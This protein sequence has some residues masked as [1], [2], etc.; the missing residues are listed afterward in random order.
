[1]VLIEAGFLGEGELV[2]LIELIRKYAA[3]NPLLTGPSSYRSSSTVHLRRLGNP[4][5]AAVEERIA[6]YVGLNPKTAEGLQGAWY[7]PGESYRIHH[8]SFHRGTKEWEQCVGTAG[9]R[10]WS[11]MAYLNTGGGETI[12]P[13]L[14]VAIEPRAGTLV[15]WANL[16]PDGSPDMRMMH[17]GGKHDTKQKFI[18]TQW[19]REREIGEI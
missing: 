3:R 5:V 1:M 16:L 9:N 2:E 8:D 10:N 17:A 12:F 15:A 6:Q 4:T 13:Q 19:F 7:Q 11:A 14:G 18:V